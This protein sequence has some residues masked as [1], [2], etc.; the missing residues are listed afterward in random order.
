MAMSRISIARFLA[1]LEDIWTVCHTQ[2]KHKSLW[3]SQTVIGRRPDIYF[4][5][6]FR[7]VYL[8]FEELHS[9]FLSLMK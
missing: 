3:K 5:N 1:K 6:N 8:Q 4:S 9:F 7:M 2:D